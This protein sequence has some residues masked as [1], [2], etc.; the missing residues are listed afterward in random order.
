M[1]WI[2]PN[3][4]RSFPSENQ[5]HS[6]VKNSQEN[7]L[8][9]LTEDVSPLVKTLLEITA[10]F[11]NVR[12]E[13]LNSTILFKS[14]AAFI[15]IKPSKKWVD[16]EFILNSEVDE[17]PIYKILQS[18]KNKYWHVVRVDCQEEIDSQ[19]IN[20]LN[21]AYDLASLKN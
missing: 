4:E 3:C 20:W 21:Q 1:S 6:C 8:K 14:R 10:S 17:F 18:S 2:C 19:L 9:D 11:D 5:W 12:R 16:I 13:F 15:A 7:F